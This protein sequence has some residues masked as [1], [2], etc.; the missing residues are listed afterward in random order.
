M[1]GMFDAALFDSAVFD[2][3][4]S[5]SEQIQQFV[6]GWVKHLDRKRTKEE[7]DA[8]RRKLGIL[9]E[10]LEISPT[11]EVLKPKPA[12]DRI[13]RLDLPQETIKV[14]RKQAYESLLDSKRKIDQRNAAID[15]ELK[16]YAQ[17]IMDDEAARVLIHYLML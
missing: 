10:E 15:A 3:G 4:E 13:P 1:S 12:I 7:I 14:D 6:G 17:K 9:P 5:V 8:E 16:I 2:T 11:V